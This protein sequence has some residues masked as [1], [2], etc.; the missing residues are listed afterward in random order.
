MLSKISYKS[1][2]KMIHIQIGFLLSNSM[3]AI[4]SYMYLSLSV[5]LSVCLSAC[6]HV[7]A[8]VC[9]LYEKQ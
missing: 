2:N 5:C 7:R 6:T 1:E 9:N 8:L 3:T 4:I